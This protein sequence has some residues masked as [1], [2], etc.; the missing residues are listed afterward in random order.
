ML[1]NYLINNLT[2]FGYEIN[3]IENL[4]FYHFIDFCLLLTLEDFSFILLVFYIITLSIINLSILIKK[5]NL[6]YIIIIPFKLLGDFFIIYIFSKF[7]YLIFYYLAFIY[8]KEFGEILYFI[9]LLLFIVTFGIAIIFLPIMY[10]K[11]TNKLIFKKI[12]N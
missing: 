9:F 7:L 1:I 2:N 3:F 10:F 8:F 11:I 5:Y 12:F 6:I 4:W